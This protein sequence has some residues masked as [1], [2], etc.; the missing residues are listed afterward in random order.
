M[1]R[2]LQVGAG[3]DISM[4]GRGEQEIL[5]E[6]GQIMEESFCQT[7]EENFSVI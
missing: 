2:V 3:V 4:L 7:K 1:D 6:K 5:A